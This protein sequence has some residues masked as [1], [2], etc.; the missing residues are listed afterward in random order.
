[1][2]NNAKAPK[3]YTDRS[4]ADINKEYNDITFKLGQAVAMEEAAIRQQNAHK[5]RLEVLEEQFGYA[6]AAEHS[7]KAAEAKATPAPEDK[8]TEGSTAEPV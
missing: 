8:P 5:D 7:K 1:M 6:S 3:G 4:A 2:S